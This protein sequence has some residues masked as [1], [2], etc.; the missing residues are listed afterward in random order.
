MNSRLPNLLK[1]ESN[2]IA[3][4]IDSNNINIICVVSN[5]SAFNNSLLPLKLD[6]IMLIDR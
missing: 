5:K 6:L 3:F 1:F 2:A 4:K